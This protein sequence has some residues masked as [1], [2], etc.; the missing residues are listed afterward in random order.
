MEEVDLVANRI[1]AAEGAEM[2]FRL[3]HRCVT[4]FGCADDAN[5]EWVVPRLYVN[6]NQAAY[7]WLS[8]LFRLLATHPID[9]KYPWYTERLHFSQT[10]HPINKEL[11]DELEC[12]FYRFNE[13]SRSSALESLT[14]ASRLQGSPIAQMAD[15]IRRIIATGCVSSMGENV[16]EDAE[17]LKNAVSEFINELSPGG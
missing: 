11:S 8:D 1:H 15:F 2:V 3:D 13:S 16:R 5:R 12:T 6:G 14:E 17:R 4:S 9:P 7:Q 10:N